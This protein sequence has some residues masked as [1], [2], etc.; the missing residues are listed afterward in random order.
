VAILDADKEGFLRDERSLIQTAGRAARNVRG[1]VI[2]YADNVTRSI[3]QALKETDRRRQK[4]V[5]YNE[6]HGVTP[7]SIE[8]SVDQVM[9]TTSVADAKTEEERA[10][11]EWRVAEGEDRMELI[12][13]LQKEMEAAAQ[14]LEFEKAAKYRDRI[15]QLRQQI[16]DDEWKESRRKKLRRK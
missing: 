13:R 1:Q 8:K 9:T 5:E 16:D 15:S 2:L 3:R 4:Q 14:A 12:A 7:R 10:D 6:K 11:G